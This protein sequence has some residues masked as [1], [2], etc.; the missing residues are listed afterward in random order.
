[1][2]YFIDCKSVL[3][4]KVSV[5]LVRLGVVVRL[6]FEVFY[7]ELLL[8][9]FKVVIYKFLTQHIDFIFLCF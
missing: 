3:V 9:V 2:F 1:M 6:G 4:F 8:E 5:L 7:V